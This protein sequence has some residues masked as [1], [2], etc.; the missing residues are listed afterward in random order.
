MATHVIVNPLNGLTGFHGQNLRRVKLTTQRECKPRE[1][2]DCI[3]PTL[4]HV[5]DD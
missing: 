3:P 1:G 4:G 2:R 5:H